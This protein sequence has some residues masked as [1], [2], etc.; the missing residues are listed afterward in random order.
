MSIKVN[1]FSGN[2]FPTSSDTKIK[3]ETKLPNAIKVTD[4]ETSSANS[5][6]ALAGQ[7]RK[8]QLLQKFG[9]I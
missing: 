2:S 5:F 8:L 9:A 6:H 7:M 1:P 4:Y 3:I